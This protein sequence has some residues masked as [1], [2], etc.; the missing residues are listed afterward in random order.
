MSQP[1]LSEPAGFNQLSKAEQIRYVQMLWDKIAAQ[2]SDVDVPESHWQ[3][4]QDRL[5]DY[6]RSPDR[7][8]PARDVL[9]RLANKPRR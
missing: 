1:P 4:L 6:R 5:A 9:D 2:P 8:A 7:V 3:V